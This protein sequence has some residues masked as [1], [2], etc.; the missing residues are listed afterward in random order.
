VDGV[1]LIDQ[2]RAIAGGVTPGDT[3][4]FPVTISATGSYRLSGN[5]TVPDKNTTAISIN[6][7][8]AA[9][10]IDLNGFSI[11]G[12]V[13]CQLDINQPGNPTVCDDAADDPSI[14]GPG[15]GIRSLASEALTVKN[16][17][18]RGMGRFA[19]FQSGGAYVIVESL[20]AR[21]NGLGG[22]WPSSGTVV[23]C[24]VTF[25]GDHGIIINAGVIKS[26]VVSR[27]VGTGIVST[28]LAIAIHDSQ[29][30]SN[31][32]LGI[33]FASWGVIGCNLIHGNTTGAI[34][35]S[36]VVSGGNH[37]TGTGCP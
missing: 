14:F 5:L 34:D 4:G 11:I 9:V 29:I 12:P 23:N 33:N 37:C 20:H 3:P 17:T 7:T 22:I 31:N 24:T 26:S 35:G 21:E 25:N 28:G 13:S 15:V 36:P 19:L 32:Q 2:N 27:N 8:A 1:V 16:G 18:I 30:N 6:N 10:T